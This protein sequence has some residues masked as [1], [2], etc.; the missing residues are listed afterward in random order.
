MSTAD[1]AGQS[2]RK[3]VLDGIWR[4][5]PVFSMVLGICSAL[6]VSNTV[7]NALAMGASVTFVLLATGFLIAMLRPLIPG[8]PI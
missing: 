7:A 1:V 4:D 8:R 5:H 6:A 2:S 3:T